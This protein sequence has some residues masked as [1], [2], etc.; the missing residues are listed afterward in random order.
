M[1]TQVTQLIEKLAAKLGTTAEFLWGVLVK[2]AQVDA[3]VATLF[4]AFTICYVWAWFVLHITFSKKHDENGY[5]KNLYDKHDTELSVPMAF[6]GFVG[7]IFVLAVFFSAIPMAVSG[8]VNPEYSALQRIL[9]T[10]K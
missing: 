3:I 5:E 6:A 7:A 1:E 10:I 9:T 4:V 8:F 2:Q